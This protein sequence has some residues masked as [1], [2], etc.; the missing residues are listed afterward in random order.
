VKAAVRLLVRFLLW[1]ALL[2]LVVSSFIVAYEYASGYDPRMDADTFPLLALYIKAIIE[3]FIPTAM[4]AALIALFDIVREGETV[5]APLALL[6]VTWS[7]LLGAGVFLLSAGG[8]QPRS[9]SPALP[10][11]RVL[12]GAD[13]SLYAAQRTGDTYAPIVVHEPGRFRWAD[14]ARLR[15]REQVLTI[16]E[17]DRAISLDDLSNSYPA[18]VQ[19]PAPLRG[20][21]ADINVLNRF[22]RG[23][24]S[25]IWLN[26]AALSVFLLGLWTLVRLTRWPLFNIV[27]VAAAWRFAVWIIP[28]VMVGSV[29]PFVVAAFSSTALATVSAALLGGIGVLLFA[30]G[31]L[32]P[33]ASEQMGDAR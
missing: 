26:L 14:E 18:M 11:Q 27:L 6:F 2:L 3:L 4:F 5:A 20:I 22:F 23:E 19:V 29:R 9:I 33:P 16:P 13:F 15:P 30:A 8:S 12:R 32:L 24:G 17:L 10:V 7:A 21:A 31:V 28:A 1:F 25:A